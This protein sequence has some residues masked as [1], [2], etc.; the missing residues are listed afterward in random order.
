MAF[1]VFPL[2]FFATLYLSGRNRLKL[3]GDFILMMGVIYILLTVFV[4]TI[5]EIIQAMLDNVMISSEE[6]RAL[7]YQYA[8]E[9]FLKYPIFGTGLGHDVVYYNPQPMAMF[10]YHSTIFQIIGSLG[11]VGIIAYTYQMLMRGK[12]LIEAHS[13]YNLYLFLSILGFAGYSLVNVGYFIPLPF[14]PTLIMLFIVSER[15]NK[16]YQHDLAYK[17]SEDIKNVVTMK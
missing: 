6:P 13:K 3:F 17:V 1:L 16:F 11:L 8:I 12:T 4:G 2:T 7:M 9:V 14:G 5:P 15:L 10:W